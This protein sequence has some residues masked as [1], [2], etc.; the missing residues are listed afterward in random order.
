[1][2]DATFFPPQ[3]LSSLAL[4]EI[5]YNPP[6]LGSFEG[7]D[8]EFVELKNRGTTTLNLSGLVLGGISFTFTNGTTLAPGEFFVLARNATA[9]A[10]KYPGVPVNGIYSGR[11]D[12][13]GE[14]LRVSF[15]FGGNIFVVTYDDDVP[16]PLAADNF[17]YSIVPK[18]SVTTQAPDKGGSWRA[19]SQRAGS[20]GADDPEPAVASIVI[21]EVFTASVSPQQD[22][23]ELFNPSASPVDI[24][25]WFSVMTQTRRRNSASRAAQ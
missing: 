14:T 3:D 21:N 2:V 22:W 25:G 1:M 4:T 20:P 6:A 10:A 9:F 24:G 8:L 16:W 11:L 18:S 17:G 23:I 15:P 5:M 13:G 7:D 12:N 19:S